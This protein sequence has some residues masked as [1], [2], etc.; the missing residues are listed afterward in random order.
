MYPPD[1]CKAIIKGY[2]LHK[3][4]RGGGQ[5][6]MNFSRSDLCDPEEEVL[7]GRYVDDIKGTELEPKLVHAARKEELDE[8]RRRK[9]YEVIPRARMPVGAKIVGVRWVETDKGNVEAPRVR[10]RLVAQ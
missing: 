10:S 5:H 4:R 6:L 1:F 2:Q 8:F 7:L 3:I 9:V